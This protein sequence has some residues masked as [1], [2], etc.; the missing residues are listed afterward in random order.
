MKENQ[1]VMDE[2]DRPDSVWRHTVTTQVLAA[3]DPETIAAAA[4]A[5]QSGELV[6]VPTDTV[7]GVGAN[8]FDDRAVRRL[9]AAK[10]RERSKGIPI[11][12]AEPVDLPTIALD[13]P[14]LAEALIA[15]FWPG[16]LTLI[17]PKHP[18]LPPS[19]SETDSIA[20]R[21]PDH[22]L[23]RAIIRACGG[24]LA[25]TSANLSGQAP[26]LVVRE[27]LDDLAGR[28][29]VAVD[30]GP[31]GGQV[32]S[33]VLDVTGDEPRILRAGPLTMDDLF[34]EARR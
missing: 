12:I 19:I 9:Y 29:A 17:L 1:V 24:A 31:S 33:T 27:A 22:A 26:A 18:D 28:A 14:P 34:Q 11:L 21:M 20:V 6:I 4:A 23:C 5:V 32:A 10:Q 25:A 30:D 8:A 7:Y 2:R 3:G 13:I 16:P 15:R